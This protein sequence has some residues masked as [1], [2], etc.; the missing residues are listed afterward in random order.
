MTEH[1]NNIFLSD[2]KL[3]TQEAKLNVLSCFDG[4]SCLQIALDR[5]GIP[6]NKY[7]ASEID[8]YA[9]Q[10]TQANYPNT[11][12]L[13]NVK[14]VTKEMLNNEIHLL[15]GGSPCQG[16]SF[17]GKQLNFEDPRSKLFFE[18]VRLKNELNPK[19]FL[20]ENV[21]MKKESQ[22]VISKY[23][24]VEPIMINSNLVSAQN[25][26]RYYWTNIPNLTLPDDK[27]ILLKDVLE[28][29]NEIV[30][31]RRGRYLVDGIR[32]DGKML[33]AGKTKQYLEIRNDE[34]SNCLT[35]VQKDNIVIRDK[36]K[37][38]RSGGRVSYDRHE[39]DSVDKKHTR[40][41]TILECERLQ[42]VPDN[43]TNHVSN[44]QRYKMLGNGW[45]VD[46]ITHILK[47][48]SEKKEGKKILLRDD[49]HEPSSL[50]LI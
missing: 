9:I 20:L 21:R 17:A 41:L 25:R 4:M 5:L 40:K 26:V 15:A 28:N 14:F 45:T 8:K 49:R 12:Q 36:S 10:V 35:T 48:M 22:D 50:A 2:G 3:L 27:N 39:W 11:I 19:Y 24:G 44:S 23:L 13:G 32:Q 33:T 46:V 43:Y 42:T 1:S 30:G 37:C 34:K 16:F 6:V 47:G 18:F 38:V 29:E 7:F 31:A